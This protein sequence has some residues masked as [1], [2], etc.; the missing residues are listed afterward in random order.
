MNMST[1]IPPPPAE[2][3]AV[4]A[5]VW[6]PPP[7]IESVSTTRF[8]WDFYVAPG[9]PDDIDATIPPCRMAA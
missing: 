3:P 2:I 1:M 4:A 9:N 8:A 7:A 6:A 5:C